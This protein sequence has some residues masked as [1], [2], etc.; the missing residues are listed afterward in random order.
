[1]LKINKNEVLINAF[2]I[3]VTY[4]VL[5]L[6]SSEQKFLLYFSNTYRMANNLIL[7]T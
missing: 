4:R 1:M 7:S 5:R 6:S 2:L 3:S